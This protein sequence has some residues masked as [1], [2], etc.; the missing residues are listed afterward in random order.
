MRFGSLE[1]SIVKYAYIVALIGAIISLIF[2]KW[3]ISVGLLLGVTASSLNFYALARSVYRLIK[4]PK[5]KATA[6]AVR[7]QISRLMFAVLVLGAAA[8]TRDFGFFIGAVVGYFLIK[9]VIGGF[10][11][12]G[13]VD[14]DKDF[15]IDEEL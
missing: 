11:I 9:L 5:S 15:D 4:L 8:Y 3:T 10:S 1:F 2:G 14:L 7:G 12:L 6:A 13:K